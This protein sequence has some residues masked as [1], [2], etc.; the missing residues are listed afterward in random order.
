MLTPSS[1]E[2]LSISD[3]SPVHNNLQAVTKTIKIAR[4]HNSNQEIQENE[5]EYF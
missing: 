3:N 5:V 4:E 2:H 1:D